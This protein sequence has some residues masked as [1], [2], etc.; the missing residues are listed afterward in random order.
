M[1][2]IRT[3]VAFCAFPA[4]ALLIPNWVA[5]ELKL[6]IKNRVSYTFWGIMVFNGL[7][8]ASYAAA[9]ANG[10]SDPD[11]AQHMRFWALPIVLAVAGPVLLA[12]LLLIDLIKYKKPTR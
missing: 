3:C 1:Y 9:A 7:V 4:A 6:R 5:L 10:P 12:P 8:L 11:T 2:G